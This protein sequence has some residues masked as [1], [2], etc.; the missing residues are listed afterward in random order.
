MVG[1]MLRSGHLSVTSVI[2]DLT[3]NSRRYET[4]LHFF[5][6]SA[7]SLDSLRTTWIQVV[8]Q[9]APPWS[10]GKRTAKKEQPS[11]AVQMIEQEF[12]A[13]QAFGN[14]LLLLDRYFLP[15]PALVRLNERHPACI[16]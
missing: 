11:H 12:A 6:S 10:G 15:V 8:R 16:W 13:A 14:A 5:R 1:F 9:T 3:L 4:L 2:R 7:W